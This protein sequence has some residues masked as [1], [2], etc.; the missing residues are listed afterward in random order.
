MTSYLTIEM[1][2]AKTLCGRLEFDASWDKAGPGYY[3]LTK[4]MK[5]DLTVTV[6]GFVAYSYVS[7][8]AAME[9]R[10]KDE[11]EEDGKSIDCTGAI[12]VR[13]QLLSELKAKLA[14]ND[15]LVR[16]LASEPTLIA[17][18]LKRTPNDLQVG[19]ILRNSVNDT[20]RLALNDVIATYFVRSKIPAKP[21]SEFSKC[22]I[23][24]LDTWSKKNKKAAGS[25]A[26]SYAERLT[27]NL[28][29]LNKGKDIIFVRNEVNHFIRREI[30]DKAALRAFFVASEVFELTDHIV[31]AKKAAKKAAAA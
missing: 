14:D 9:S 13:N 3:D 20:I 21:V 29:T 5:T 15:V 27:A 18:T 6:G 7:V 25:H 23:E 11:E 4:Q 31:T 17:A 16:L 22:V 2:D 19:N 12:H 8:L 28:A 26:L 10:L 30:R 1:G 24:I